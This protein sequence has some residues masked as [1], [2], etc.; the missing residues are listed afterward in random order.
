[1][2]L[3]GLGYDT[4]IKINNAVCKDQKHITVT[5]RALVS[6][7]PFAVVETLLK[8]FSREFRKQ[9][10]KDKDVRALT[11]NVLI[12]GFDTGIDMGGK[13][14]EKMRLVREEFEKKTGLSITG[15]SYT[16]EKVNPQTNELPNWTFHFSFY[17]TD[18][19]DPFT[20]GKA[21]NLYRR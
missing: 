21:W 13:T 3:D 5:F 9:H 18:P 4:Q 17:D 10:E 2:N 8:T 12:K 15:Y 19:K 11:C 1:M 16:Y 14:S 6:A 20:G 7:K